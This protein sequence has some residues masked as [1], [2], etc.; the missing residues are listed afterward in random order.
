MMVSIILLECFFALGKRCT[1]ILS[2]FFDRLDG[3]FYGGEE[4]RNHFK[5]IRYIDMDVN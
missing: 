5:H 2:K 1:G 3:N 4:F